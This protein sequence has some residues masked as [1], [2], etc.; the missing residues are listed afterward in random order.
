MLPTEVSHFNFISQGILSNLSII[1]K[2][3][4]QLK[5]IKGFKKKE[6]PPPMS[7]WGWFA[8]G[9]RVLLTF[10]YKLLEVSVPVPINIEVLSN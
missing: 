9:L 4:N 3:Q 10:L 2:K 1:N 8:T 7:F 5:E 6:A